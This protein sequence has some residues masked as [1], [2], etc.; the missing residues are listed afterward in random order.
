MSIEKI[1]TLAIAFVLVTLIGSCTHYEVTNDSKI[2]DSI[3]KGVD[4]LR[5]RCAFDAYAK[6]E[7]MCIIEAMK[8]KGENK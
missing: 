1:V 2:A 7:A 3:A 6:Y 8:T 4:P 5:A